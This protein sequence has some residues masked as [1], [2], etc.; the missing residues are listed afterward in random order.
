LLCG[1][2]Q[3]AGEM[4]PELNLLL[5]GKSEPQLIEGYFALL[6]LRRGLSAARV[7]HWRQY[8]AISRKRA[9]STSGDSCFAGICSCGTS[10]QQAGTAALIPDGNCTTIHGSSFRQK[11][12]R[13]VPT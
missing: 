2:E 10:V 1:L 7:L 12:S 6:R 5:R 4:A 13:T 9:G 8:R 11:K 3:H